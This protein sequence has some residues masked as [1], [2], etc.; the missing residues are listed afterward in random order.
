MAKV[1]AGLIQ[2]S[3][4]GDTGQ[5]PERIREQMVEAHLPFIAEAARQHRADIRRDPVRF[6]PEERPDAGFGI[7]PGAVNR[8][9]DGCHSHGAVA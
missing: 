9:L 2:M 6:W 8:P 5:T 1:K 4:K 3:L 7:A